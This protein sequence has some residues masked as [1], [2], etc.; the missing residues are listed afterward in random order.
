MEDFAVGY[1][2]ALSSEDIRLQDKTD[3]FKICNKVLDNWNY[4]KIKYRDVSAAD[5]A[6]RR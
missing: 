3:S 2:Q 5:M 4:V 1:K 6:R